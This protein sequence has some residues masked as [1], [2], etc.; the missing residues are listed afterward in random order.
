M[1]RRFGD[2]G[3]GWRSAEVS[4]PPGHYK[5][6]FEGTRGMGYRADIAIDD[7][8]VRPGQCLNEGKNR[9]EFFRGKSVCLKTVFLLRTFQSG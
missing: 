1:L 5:L 6:M 7:I 3:D 8:S 2:H 9:F 4:L